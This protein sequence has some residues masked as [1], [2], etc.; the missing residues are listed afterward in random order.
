MKDEGRAWVWQEVAL[1]AAA[2]AASAAL[3]WA[4]LGLGQADL[5][6]PLAISTTSDGVYYAAQVKTL[7]ET[8]WVYHH[9]GLGAPNGLDLYDFPH[10]DAMHLLLMKLIGYA[11]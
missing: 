6:Y 1:Y 3:L 2:W 5:R 11:A 8:G 10:F 7:L 9:P 4:T